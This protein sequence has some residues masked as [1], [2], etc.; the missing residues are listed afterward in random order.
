MRLLNNGDS[1]KIRNNTIVKILK[2]YC[3]ALAREEDETVGYICLGYETQVSIDR[4][5]TV[6]HMAHSN[7]GVFGIT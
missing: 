4:K 7:R 1:S 6:K 2:L 3:L 5:F